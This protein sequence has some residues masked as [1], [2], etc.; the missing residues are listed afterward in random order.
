MKKLLAIIVLG[1]LFSGCS[2]KDRSDE[3]GCTYSDGSGPLLV[4]VSSD[5]ITHGGWGSPIQ[6]ENNEKI[7][8]VM[9]QGHESEQSTTFYKRT[10]KLKVVY[11]DRRLSTYLLS[12][13]K[14]N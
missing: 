12:C 10:N 3:F 13:D 4:T 1:L 8:A 7:I 5:F 6:D 14:L 2:N 9:F 11:N